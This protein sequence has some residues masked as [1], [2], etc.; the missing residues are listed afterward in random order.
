[1]AALARA[2]LLEQLG[3]KNLFGDLELALAALAPGG[4][5]PPSSPPS[6]TQSP[7]GGR[8]AEPLKS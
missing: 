2:G 3:E 4:E 6:S 7:P 8:V 1:M 5:A